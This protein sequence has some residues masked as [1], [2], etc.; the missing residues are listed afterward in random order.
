MKKSSLEMDLELCERY[1]YDYIEIR[2]DM[3]QEYLKNNTIEDLKNFSSIVI[4]NH[5]L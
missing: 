3:L 1:R 4:L 2:L 5:T